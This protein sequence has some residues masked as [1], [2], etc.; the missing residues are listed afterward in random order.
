M[1][2]RVLNRY[3]GWDFFKSFLLTVAVLTFV[4][5][6]GTVVKAID[7]MTRGVSGL[8]IMRIFAI[9]IPF[10]L[11]FVIPMSVLTTVLLHFGRLS[12][13]GEI[14][15]MKASGISLWQIASPVLLLAAGLSGLCLWINSEV[16][17]ASHYARRQLTRDLGDEDPLA[18]LSEGTF[19]DDFPGVKIYCGK[20]DGHRIEDLIFIKFGDDAAEFELKAKVGIAEY[21]PET[22][23]LNIDLQQVRISEFDSAT[24]A[25]S[26]TLS[27]DSY[28]L[29]LNL[30]SILSKK[31][32]LRKKPSD[33]GFLEL[34]MAIRNIRQ[35]FPDILEENVAP[36]R[37]KMAVDATQ[38]VAL[39]LA[40]FSFAVLGIPLG[41]QSSRRESSVG[42]GLALIVFFLFYLFIIIADALVDRPEWRSDL[43][44]WI[45]VL[46]AQVGGAW[47]MHSRR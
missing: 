21:D 38:R 26:R 27:A 40:C 46:G 15:A 11:T 10:T 35:V 8:L 25:A 29:Q 1:M 47:L 13:D 30:D 7:Y 20:K 9:Q 32:K 16:A 42:I 4:M 45:P 34:V 3:I 17:P 19:V 2:V 28:P 37:A 39:A 6:I 5:Y 24:G 14:T 18:L 43:L 36:M 31:G 41:I 12:A 33:M 22:R 44:P 23:V